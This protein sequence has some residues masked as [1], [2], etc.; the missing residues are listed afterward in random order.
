[1]LAN[2]SLAVCVGKHSKHLHWRWIVVDKLACITVILISRIAGRQCYED[3]WWHFQ[4]FGVIQILEPCKSVEHFR[5]RI[6]IQT[7]V[8]VTNPLSAPLSRGMFVPSA[9][10]YYSAGGVPVL[11][12][13]IYW[14]ITEYYSGLCVSSQPECWQERYMWHLLT[15]GNLRFGQSYL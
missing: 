8:E 13:L 7:E 1:M 12:Y 2:N 6:Q 11:R 3:Y 5:C 9:D 10:V 14:V 15:P 4:V